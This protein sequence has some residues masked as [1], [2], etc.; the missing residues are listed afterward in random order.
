MFAI[1]ISCLVPWMSLER[2]EYHSRRNYNGV[3][4]EMNEF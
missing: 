2:I 3:T 1:L 4:I